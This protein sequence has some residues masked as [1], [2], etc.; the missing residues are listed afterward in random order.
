VLQT[1]DTKAG[2]LET[3]VEMV[4]R[5]GIAVVPPELDFGEV[6]VAG[7]PER[8]VDLKAGKSRPFKVTSV[9]A[10]VPF[11]S[12]EQEPLQT[13]DRAGVRLHVKV[14]PGAPVR[15]VRSSRPM[16]P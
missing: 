9:D 3:D 16:T 15:P 12:V 14:A 1:N 7:S 5:P 4:I 2:Q 6:P 13:D 11:V 8:T 10:G